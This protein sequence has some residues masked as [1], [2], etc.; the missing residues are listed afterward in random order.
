[1]ARLVVGPL[2]R[3]VDENSATIWVETDQPCEVSVLGTSTRTFTVH[4]HH[5][6]LVELT[7]LAPGRSTPYT[8]ELDGVQVWP[9]PDSTFPPSRI[10]TF[11]T[12]RPLRL[13]VGSCRKTASHGQEG[14]ET[15]GVDALRTYAQRMAGQPEQEWPAALL[16]VGDQ[17][18]AD[19]PSGEMKEIIEARRDVTQPPGHELADFEEYTHLYRLAWAGEP[20]A[21]TDVVRWLLSTVP[22]M[23]IFDDH[24]VRDDWNISQAWRERVAS[25]SWW[26]DRIVGGFGTYWLYQHLG[27]LSPAELVADPL[28]TALRHTD[29]DGGE[30]VDELAWHADRGSGHYRWSYA[31][32]FG[33]TRLAVLDT[34][35]ARELQ[36]GQRGL[37]GDKQW[38]WFDDLA[39][40]DLDHLLIATSLPYLLPAGVHHGEAWNEA[41][42]EGGWGQRGQRMGERVRNLRFL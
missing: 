37:L 34:R 3:Y 18:Y 31:R 19:N 4:G 29:G 1:M 8:M 9:P 24:D 26:H 36:P 23:M 41:V 13:V 42:C 40:G 11:G 2:L 16:M 17:V 28:L 27:N 35:S 21:A 5:Y 7:D 6:A 30:L 32:D 12:G 39:H 15:F 33:R 25:E 38:S 10:C 14:E 22:S 20:N